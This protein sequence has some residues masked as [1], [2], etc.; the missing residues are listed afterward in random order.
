MQTQTPNNE[1]PILEIH[2]GIKIYVKYSGRLLALENVEWTEIKTVLDD[3]IN[4][5]DDVHAYS[6]LRHRLIETGKLV[7][8]DGSVEIY[9]G[10]YSGVI[11]IDMLLYLIARSR[12]DS[13][14][15]YA[16]VMRLEDEDKSFISYLIKSKMYEIDE[17]DVKQL[18]KIMEGIVK[19]RYPGFIIRSRTRK[20][21]E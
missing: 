2:R 7:V 1:T 20:T 17:N 10:T 11:A 19:Y 21:E 16:I 9:D 4:R 6:T 13:E 5:Y 8:E 3:I 14:T 15:A 18:N 12:Y